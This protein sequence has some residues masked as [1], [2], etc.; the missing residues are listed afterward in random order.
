MGDPHAGEYVGE[1]LLGAGASG[2]VGDGGVVGVEA[3]LLGAVVGDEVGD[4]WRGAVC[5]GACGAVVE[6]GVLGHVGVS[7][8]CVAYS[9]CVGA[10]GGEHVVAAWVGGS[11]GKVVEEVSVAVGDAVDGGGGLPLHECLAELAQVG[12]GAG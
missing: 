1:E 12:E 2:G 11:A 9:A 4:G 3:A 10:E 5:D 7:H 8:E 6:V